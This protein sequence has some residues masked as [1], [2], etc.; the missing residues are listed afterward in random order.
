MERNYNSS[1]ANV[2]YFRHL[3][4]SIYKCPLLFKCFS[5]CYSY[6]SYCNINLFMYKNQGLFKSTDVLTL[7][8]YVSYIK[9]LSVLREVISAPESEFFSKSS[10][11]GGSDCPELPAAMQQNADHIILVTFQNILSCRSSTF[12]YIL[13]IHSLYIWH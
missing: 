3:F 1:F 4:L 12:T 10:V 5:L 2:F 11:G 6:K 8:T 7:Q 13:F 9:L